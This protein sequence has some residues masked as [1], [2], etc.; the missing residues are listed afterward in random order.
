MLNELVDQEAGSAGSTETEPWHGVGMV[1]SMVWIMSVAKINSH[2][3]SEH[4]CVLQLAKLTAWK[5]S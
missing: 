3:C 2:M 4:S 5:L 1:I